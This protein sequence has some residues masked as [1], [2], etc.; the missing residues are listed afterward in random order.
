[1]NDV[2][3]APSPVR[4]GFAAWRYFWR[5]LHPERVRLAVVVFAATLQPAILLPIALSV[6]DIFDRYLP[7]GE[8][9]SL[10][11]STLV[12]TVLYFASSATTVWIRYRLLDSTKRA[13]KSLRVATLQTLFSLSRSDLDHLH[14]ADLHTVVVQDTER[15]DVATNAIL[16]YFFPSLCTAVVLSLVLVGLKAPLFVLVMGAYFLMAVLARTFGRRTRHAAR[17]YHQAFQDFSKGMLFV[18]QGM[19]LIK[20]QNAEPIEMVRQTGRFGRVQSTSGQMAWL[21]AIFRVTQDSVLV[22]FISLVLAVGGYSVVSGRMS[23][24]EL[25]AFYTVLALVRPQMQSLFS[26]I[27][28][29]IEG[30]EA[31]LRLQALLT[32]EPT[33]AYS[34]GE[35]IR[36]AGHIGLQ[37]VHFRYDVDFVLKG[38]SLEFMPGATYALVG[39][40]GS[41]KTT[42]VNLVLGFYRPQVGGLTADG[43][44]FES[45]DLTAVRRRFGVVP[46]DP[47]II[48]GTILEN[49]SYGNPE[50]PLEDIREAAH[51]ATAD[52]FIDEMSQGYLTPVGQDG[53]LLSGGQR[54]RIALARSLL[55]HPR[56]LIL[57][58]PTNHLDQDSIRR[59]M[60][61]LRALRN[62]PTIL[63][64]SHSLDIVGVADCVYVL[65]D[66]RIA[67][68]GRPEELMPAVSSPVPRWNDMPHDR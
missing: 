52:E 62:S 18:L 40:N 24:G 21:G 12:I 20:L 44:P 35:A 54:Q 49:I 38:V 63:L 22:V 30:H 2:H 61:N 14:S 67:A 34:G 10:V 5:F 50:A 4:N 19:P 56:F 55:G 16:A 58:E 53:S 13:I 46:Q 68:S 1:M 66:G 57:D 33:H 64:I 31:L 6:R 59:V 39:K 8:A 42:L 7:A 48:A 51:L 32:R 60:R 41:G 47:Q 9:G 26:S 25:L 3:T 11:V 27:S 65:E 17:A 15:L 29:I 23:V 36:F 37:N 45:L 28:P 43:Y